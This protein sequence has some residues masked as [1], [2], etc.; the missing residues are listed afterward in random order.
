MLESRAN[1][2]LFALK[3][4]EIQVNENTLQILF[5]SILR[6]FNSECI[7]IEPDALPPTS[8]GVNLVRIPGPK[9][10]EPALVKQFSFPFAE[11]YRS[12]PLKLLPY[13][14]G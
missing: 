14:F 8:I 12:A 5:Q 3:I 7:G 4:T 1:P 13:L 11:G 6:E 10:S 9:W 2:N